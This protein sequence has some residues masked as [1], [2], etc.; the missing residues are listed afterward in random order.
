MRIMTTMLTVILA[1]LMAL[2]SCDR[3]LPTQVQ[4]AYDALPEEVDYNIHVQPIL[5]DRCY[6]CHGP[7]EN[8]RKAGLRLDLEGEAFDKLSSGRHAMVKGKP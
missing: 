1:I 8:T 7:D 2:T 3:T 5:S 6:Q 4:V